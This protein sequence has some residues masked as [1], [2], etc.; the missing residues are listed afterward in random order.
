MSFPTA[1]PLL[2]MSHIPTF[3][4]LILSFKYCLHV[5]NDLFL[6][7]SN[8]SV[9]VRFDKLLNDIGFFEHI[10]QILIVLLIKT[11]FWM[12]LIIIKWNI[13]LK[14]S[15]IWHFFKEFCFFKF[16]YLGIYYYCVNKD[17]YILN[18]LFLR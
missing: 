7:F 13:F 4:P 10:L 12:T 5:P 11:F 14:K 8:A 17:F 9:L 6:Y 3:V 15:K 1:L 18:L 16:T 2:Y